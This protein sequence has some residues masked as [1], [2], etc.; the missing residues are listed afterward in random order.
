[1][2]A[3]GLDA[4]FKNMMRQHGL[5]GIFDAWIVSELVGADKPDPAMFRAAMDALGL[6]DADKSRILMIG[7]NVKRDIRGGNRFGIR[8][9]LLTWS[10]RRSFEP[11]EPEDVP[12]YRIGEPKELAALV[13]RLEN[14]N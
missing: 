1:M 3:D 9:A 6:T 11:E 8:T 7:N 14:E 13:H 12:T 4:S 2:V 10:K 5:T